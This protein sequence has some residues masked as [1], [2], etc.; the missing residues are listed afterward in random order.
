MNKEPMEKKKKKTNKQRKSVLPST[1]H[2]SMVVCFVIC[3]VAVCLLLGGGFQLC[4][5]LEWMKSFL[6]HAVAR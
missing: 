4:G 3:N 6:F 5:D 2:P 1:H